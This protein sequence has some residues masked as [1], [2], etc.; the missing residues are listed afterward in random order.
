MQTTKDLAASPLHKGQPAPQSPRWRWTAFFG[1]TMISLLIFFDAGEGNALSGILPLIKRDLHLNLLQVFI[2]SYVSILFYAVGAI[3]L[4]LLADRIKR[5]PIIAIGGMLA[6]MVVALTSVAAGSWGVLAILRALSGG[7]DASY[8][9]PLLSAGTDFVQ[10]QQRTGFMAWTLMLGAAG[11]V[12]GAASASLIAVTFG[13]HA[14]F[15]INGFVIIF[16]S[17]A[18]FLVREPPRMLCENAPHLTPQIGRQILH[19]LLNI[20]LLRLC[21]FGM[22]AFTITTA[23]LGGVLSLFLSQSYHVP[24][25]L[26]GTDVG[27]VFLGSVPGALLSSWVDWLLIT[28][29]HRESSNVIAPVRSR[30]LL[31]GIG[32]SAGSILLI[33]TLWRMP[34]LPNFLLLASS[35]SACFGCAAAPIQALIATATPAANRTTGYMIQGVVVAIIGAALALA[36][37][38]VA[39]QLHT[40]S[41]VMGM[42][43][44]PMLAAGSAFLLVGTRAREVAHV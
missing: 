25:I 17:A 41:L 36:F 15:L 14:V 1:L 11:A 29:W 39:N 18:F 24:A 6:G 12:F 34:S 13:W 40:L 28:V 4:A 21:I 44:I 20:P 8:S 16:V 23:T 19:A 37:G 27:I 30:T 22:A 32:A 38:F 31:A 9:A 43:T 10:E 26:I 3:P 7:G 5:M 33:L 35:A 2:L 42:A